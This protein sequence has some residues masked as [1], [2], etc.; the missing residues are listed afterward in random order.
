MLLLLLA[1]LGAVAD[2]WTPIFQVE[3]R[4]IDQSDAE[5][6]VVER[7]PKIVV[8]N[9]QSG[10]LKDQTQR[11]FVT[12]VTKTKTGL[13]PTVK[14]V[15]EGVNLT[16]TPTIVARG[17]VSLDL[18]IQTAKVKSVEERPVDDDGFSPARP[19]EGL[20]R[21]PVRCVRL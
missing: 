13:N 19:D 14:A 10:T 8:D 4:I 1:L 11:A 17:E 15:T 9:G 16:V 18:T 12:G 21:H 6:A 2:D 20:A 3:V 7:A 5:S